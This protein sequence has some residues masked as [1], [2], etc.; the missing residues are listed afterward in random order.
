MFHS[1]IFW[2]LEGTDDLKMVSPEAT[3][4]FDRRP[5]SKSAHCMWHVTQMQLQGGLKIL[6]WSS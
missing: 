4:A 3:M 2:A 1:E 6:A 5:L